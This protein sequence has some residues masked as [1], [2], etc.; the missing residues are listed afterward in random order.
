V[1]DLPRIIESLTRP[2]ALYGRD[3]V[4][5]KPCPVPKR[6]GLYAW[7]FREI[8]PNVPTVGCNQFNGLQLLYVGISPHNAISSQQLQRRVRYHFRGNAEGSTLRLTLGVLLAGRSD[9]PLRRVGSGTRMTFTHEGERWLDEWMRSNAFVNWVEH[10]APW[11]LEAQ[12]FRQLNLPLNIQD[13]SHHPFAAELS[14]LR[15][16]AKQSAREGAI[17]AEGNQRR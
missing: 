16:I 7:Y 8:P 9:F 10:D 6:P 2:T 15:R 3:D 11:E 5:A 14:N 4:L 13:N 17:A 12:I 1:T